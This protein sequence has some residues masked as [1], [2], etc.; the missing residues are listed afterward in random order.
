MIVRSILTYL[1]FFSISLVSYSQS[2]LAYTDNY[3]NALEIARNQD[4]L[5]YSIYTEDQLL[6]EAYLS[7]LS[8]NDS[9]ST[10]LKDHF[11]IFVDESE[12][13]SV[14]ITSN[15]G[16]LLAILD[17]NTEI[18][19]LFNFVNRICDSISLVKQY[20]KIEDRLENISDPEP[21][22]IELYTY[23]ACAKDIFELKKEDVL[24]MFITK[25]PSNKLSDGR[26]FD[27][28]N[29]H[30]T[31]LGKGYDFLK[32]YKNLGFVRDSV[33]LKS[34]KSTIYEVLLN[35][36]ELVLDY[37]EELVTKQFTEEVG[38]F[39]NNFESQEWNNRYRYMSSKYGVASKQRGDKKVL[40]VSSR[41][42]IENWVMSQIGSDAPFMPAESIGY[43]LVAVIDLLLKRKIPKELYPQM[44]SWVTTAL[45]LLPGFQSNRAYSEWL[46]RVGNKKESNIQKNRYKQFRS[47]LS[48][49][50]VKQK[51]NR[52][53]N[54]LDSHLVLLEFCEDF[55][56]F[57][58][59]WAL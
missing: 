26:Y 23:L 13:N 59:N 39:I 36:Y 44:E 5:L 19:T 45:K 18:D 29:F 54:N 57:R 31:S 9:L 52:L 38:W 33:T 50:V 47:Q 53:K 43:D 24:E 34:I 41:L 1:L 32:Q 27:L 58:D 3:K 48:K 28:I 20:L 56:F 46:K 4:K 25:L 22:H 49:D 16:S 37:D 11:I 10:L 51:E 55:F 30:T 35:T 8:F 21:D 42:F 40:F 7:Y 17:L 2:S 12:Y 14:E 6:K 15:T